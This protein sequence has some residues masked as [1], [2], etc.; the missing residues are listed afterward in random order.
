MFKAP[1]ANPDDS[2]DQLLLVVAQNDDRVNVCPQPC[3]EGQSWMAR[4]I[5]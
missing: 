4:S 2:S 3:K 5:Y 1:A